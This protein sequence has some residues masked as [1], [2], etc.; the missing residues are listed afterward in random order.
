M[1]VLLKAGFLKSSGASAWAYAPAAI[2]R[3]VEK[4]FHFIKTPKKR[5]NNIG[6]RKWA[7]ISIFYS[8]LLF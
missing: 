7:A 5:L 6:C 4:C 3:T 1:W 2:R 8:Y